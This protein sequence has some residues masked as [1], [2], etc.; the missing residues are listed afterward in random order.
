VADHLCGTGPINEFELHLLR[1]SLVGR[2]LDV[3]VPSWMADR[4]RSIVGAQFDCAHMAA[5]Q[6]S[7]NPKF[8]FSHMGVPHLP[9]I[10]SADGHAAPNDVYL[11]PLEVPD[12]MR[13]RVDGA[14]VDQL[15]YLNEL[16]LSLV[17]AIEDADANAVVIVMADHGSWLGIGSDYDESSDLRER[18]GILFAARTPGHADLFPDDVT[19]GQ[20][21]PMLFNAYLS[22]DITVPEPEYYF[23]RTED[24]FSLTAIPDPF[25]E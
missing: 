12:A 25:G 20:V 22:T 7:Q 19:V 2:V 14:Y 13:E 18:F 6:A 10:Y 24:V 16:T 15:T 3:V 4:D 9:V 8:V 17:D 23:S 11:D 5:G 21:L 1:S